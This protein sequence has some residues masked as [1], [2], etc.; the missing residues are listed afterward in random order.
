MATQILDD[1]LPLVPKVFTHIRVAETPEEEAQAQRAVEVL[2]VLPMTDWARMS[3]DDF[4]AMAREPEFIGE[5]PPF[6]REVLCRLAA[7]LEFEK[8]LAFGELD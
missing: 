5:C 1:D 8:A 3:D 7:R 4:V 6:A 2:T